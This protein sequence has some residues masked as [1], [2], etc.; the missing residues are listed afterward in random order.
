[1][2]CEKW[3]MNPTALWHR[4]LDISGIIQRRQIQ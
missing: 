4:L 2:Q 1:M 3:L